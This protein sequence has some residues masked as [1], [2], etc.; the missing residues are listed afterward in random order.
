MP[1]S[2]T[3]RL[4]SCNL[5][6]DGGPDD[7]SGELPSLWLK[8]TRKLASLKAHGILR[9]EMTYSPADSSRLRAAE[10]ILGMPG[11]V[12]PNHMGRHPTGLFLRPD[13]FLGAKQIP[14]MAPW[15]TPPTIVSTRFAGAPEVELLIGSIH[16][17]FNDRLGRALEVG[18][19]TAYADK[20][21]NSKGLI[22][23]GDFNEAPFPQGEVVKAIDWASPEI[24]DSVH[25]VHRTVE[26]PHTLRAR[27][28]HRLRGVFPGPR[29][30]PAPLRVSCNYVDQTLLEC[31]LHDAAR[32]HA[33]KSGNRHCLGPTA[34]HAPSAKG[35]GGPQRI[36]RI[37]LDAW[38][39][40][41]II[42][43][44]LIDMSGLS[45]HHAVVV[46]LSAS[47]MAQALRRQVAPHPWFFDLAY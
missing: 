14:K 40:T 5:E 7:E 9:Q 31:G 1:T 44:E 36:D 20:V 42:N 24:T 18:D 19:A 46:D 27:T 41:A 21:K 23:G 2:D 45:D 11:F 34:G 38:L 3:V 17:A 10:A 39:A 43:V 28:L 12:S 25:R 29:R 26:I 37:M 22:W 6:R 16:H 30:P 15:R 47:A 13:V 33:A 4:I 32:Y 35:Q 8:A